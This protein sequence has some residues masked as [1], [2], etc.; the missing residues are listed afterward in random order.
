[1]IRVVPDIRPD[2]QPF[3]DIR[4]P[5]GYP[6]SFAGYP[7]SGKFIG[8]ISGKISIRYNP[9]FVECFID[10][11]FNELQ[12]TE[13]RAAPP[14]AVPPRHDVPHSRRSGTGG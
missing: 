12:G 7:V 1:M 6:V 8:R 4:Y 9:S 13:D 10:I 5:A 14:P 3:F 11:N 2:I